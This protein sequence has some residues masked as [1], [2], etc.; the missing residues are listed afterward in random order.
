MELKSGIVN[1]PK[2]TFSE[3]WGKINIINEGIFMMK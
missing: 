3:N 2:L 1:E